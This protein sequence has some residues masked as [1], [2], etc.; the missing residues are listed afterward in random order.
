M[1]GLIT[2]MILIV[3][4]MM[5]MIEMMRVSFT[6]AVRLWLTLAGKGSNCLY[7]RT[8][9]ASKTKH[10]RLWIHLMFLAVQARSS[11]ALGQRDP[12]LAALRHC[13]DSLRPREDQGSF[14]A[15]VTS[16]FPSAKVRLSSP[17]DSL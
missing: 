10:A 6:E 8:F 12:S 2:M 3:I 9:F 7:D 11:L 13:W 17:I 4:M 14:L 1:V 5:I 15:L 16:A